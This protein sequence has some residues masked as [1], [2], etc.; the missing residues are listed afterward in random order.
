MNHGLI[1]HAILTVFEQLGQSISADATEN[2]QRNPRIVSRWLAVG[3][4]RGI[5]DRT[6]HNGGKKPAK[7]D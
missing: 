4:R 2:Q 3:K 6:T 5:V 7:N 1:T